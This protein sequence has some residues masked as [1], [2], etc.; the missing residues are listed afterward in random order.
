L[1]PEKLIA[2][3]TEH[4][5]AYQK[6]I[7]EEFGCSATAIYL[8][9]KRLKIT[10]QKKTTRYREQEEK[11]VAAYQAEINAYPLEKMAY[12]DECGIDT[13]LYWEYGY[14]ARGQKIFIRV[15]GCKYKQRGI[16]AAEMNGRILAP[17]QYDGTMDSPLYLPL[18]DAFSFCCPKSGNHLHLPSTLL[19]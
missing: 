14:A 8:A 19:P 15:S 3:V 5:D 6:K 4:P 18:Q 9:M 13:Y 1:N 16:V 17:L 12:V 10:R 11:K 7:V 2:Y